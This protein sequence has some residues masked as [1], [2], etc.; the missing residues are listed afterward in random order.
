MTATFPNVE[1][2]AEYAVEWRWAGGALEAGFSA[3]LRVRNEARNLPFVL[4]PL[5]RSMARV[6]IVDNASTDGSVDVARDVAAR[7]RAE[8]VLEIVSYP[9]AIARCGSEH[10]D[11]PPDSV[12]SLTYFYNWSFSRAV[13]TYV[14]KWDGDMV[15]TGEGEDVFRDLAWQIEGQRARI[16]MMA[17]PLYVESSERAWADVQIRHYE[18]YAW[19]N[20]EGFRYGKCFDWEQFKYPR[21]V[22]TKTLPYGVCL[23]IKRLDVDEFSNW[24]D[25]EFDDNPR[26]PR[27]RRERAV[28]RGLAAGE[29]VGGLVPLS[30]P[31]G[32]QVVDVARQTRVPDWL[33]MREESRPVSDGEP[34]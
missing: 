12:R 27:K 9:F 30:V 8:D 18:T 24:S 2:L 19:P 25:V 22:A 15:L 5:F 4:P 10:V 32:G 26:L 28:F 20:A 23:E 31:P 16:R 7:E 29:P 34:R 11:T 14:V 13:T 21:Q 3:V 6:L 17:I 1:Q 33:A